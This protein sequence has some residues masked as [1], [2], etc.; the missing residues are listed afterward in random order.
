MKAI[1]RCSADH[2]DELTF[3]EGEVI[4]VEGEEDSEWWVSRFCGVVTSSMTSRGSAR[5]SSLCVF[6]F[7]HI[8]NEPSRRGL[9]PVTF[10]HFFTD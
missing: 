4:V 1:Y 7:G 9:F 10:V 5:L 2:P 8:E 6:Q 3:S